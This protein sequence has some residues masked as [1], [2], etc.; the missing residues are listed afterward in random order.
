[1]STR[2]IGAE[3]DLAPPPVDA[4]TRPGSPASA[5]TTSRQRSGV[6]TLARHGEPNISRRVKLHAAEYA[7]W[8]GRYELTGLR[9]GQAAPAS[10]VSAAGEARVILCSTRLR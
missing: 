1:M 3:S 8:W 10:L 4:V 6:I 9:P 2:P 7:A 5:P